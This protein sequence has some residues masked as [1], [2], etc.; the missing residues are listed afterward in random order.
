M[1][2]HHERRDKN[3]C[4]ARGTVPFPSWNRKSKEVLYYNLLPVVA[5]LLFFPFFLPE[6]QSACDHLAGL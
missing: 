1:V 5:A 3:I 6:R 4:A 2:L